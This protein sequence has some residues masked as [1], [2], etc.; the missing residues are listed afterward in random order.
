[1]LRVSTF[2]MSSSGMHETNVI[3][4]W[5]CQCINIDPYFTL[6]GFI[7]SQPSIKILIKQLYSPILLYCARLYCLQ[8]DRNDGSIY[9]FCKIQFIIIK[10]NLRL[11]T[12]S[13]GTNHH[14]QHLITPRICH[15]YHTLWL[16][17]AHTYI[18]SQLSPRIKWHGEM[19][20]GTILTT[21]KMRG[22]SNCWSWPPM[23]RHPTVSGVSQFWGII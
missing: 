22:V 13:G 17:S 6:I 1:M 9:S 12:M 14:S 3:S 5:I 2:F 8:T 23:G 11:E 7:I 21:L 19:S 16:H 20:H 4:F 15:I 10:R 18:H